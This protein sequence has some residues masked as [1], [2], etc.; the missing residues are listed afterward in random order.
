[1]IKEVCHG[2]DNTA[3]QKYFQVKKFSLMSLQPCVMA[4]GMRSMTLSSF[5]LLQQIHH[6]AF[7]DNHRSHTCL[8]MT[9]LEWLSSIWLL[10]LLTEILYQ[11]TA[12]FLPVQY[13]VLNF[14]EVTSLNYLGHQ[15][16]STR[17]WRTI[18]FIDRMQFGPFLHIIY[19]SLHPQV[20]Q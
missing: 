1:M 10:F 14:S 7:A 9:L 5:S 2:K 3:S 16:H 19:A 6:Q 18:K 12:I 13:I 8:L 15:F 20:D 11:L 17:H 4:L